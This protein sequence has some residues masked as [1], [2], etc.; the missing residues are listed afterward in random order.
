MPIHGAGDR[1]IAWLG[2]T[3]SG[4]AQIPSGY[5]VIFGSKFED[6]TVGFFMKRQ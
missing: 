2:Q 4:I 3:S 5:T 6:S 1:P